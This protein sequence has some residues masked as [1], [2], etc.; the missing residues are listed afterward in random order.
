M[1]FPHQMPVPSSPSVP[2]ATAWLHIRGPHNSF[3]RF[4]ICL[5]SNAQL[6]LTQGNTVLLDCQFIIKD[7]TQ[8]QPDGR[9]YGVRGGA[10][11]VA[12]PGSL[13]GIPH[14]STCVHQPKSFVNPIFR[15]FMQASLCR[16]SELNPW[17]L[18]I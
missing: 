15:G 7:T 11:G 6:E 8:E 16:C 14:P 17:P 12:I 5:K 13:R 4:V 10:R 3:L 1:G 2:S 9:V 18:V